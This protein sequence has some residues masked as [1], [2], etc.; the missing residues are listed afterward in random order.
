MT[1]TLL[2]C[3][4]SKI[5]NSTKFYGRFELGTWSPGQAITIA[6]AL[7]RGLL[8]ELPGTSITF[9]KIIGTSHEYDTLPGIRECILDI[10]LNLKKII[11]KSEFKIFSP[12]IGFLNVKGPGIIRSRDLKLPFFIN[13]IDP[14]QY[15]AT[16]TNNSQLNIKFLI[17]SGKKYLI[18]TPSSNHYLNWVNLLEKQKPI[19]LI[20]NNKNKILLDNYRKWKK[21]R[22]LNK[23]NFSLSLILL[24]YSYL[25]GFYP[26]LNNKKNILI[27]Y[28]LKNNKKKIK[29]INLINN[30]KKINSLINFFNYNSN[31]IIENNIFNLKK[32][33]KKYKNNKFNKI[34]YFPIDAIFSPILRVNYT[35]EIK[36]SITKRE[37]IFLEIWT[38]GT[39]DPRS[40]IH[41]TIKILIKL[42][43]PLQQLKVNFFNVCKGKVYLNKL[44]SSYFNK[45]IIQLTNSYYKNKNLNKIINNSLKVI[46][47]NKLKN[48]NFLFIRNKNK[49]NYFYYYIINTN[50]NNNI[51]NI[52][53]K[54]FHYKKNYKLKHLL[55]Y[56]LNNNYFFYKD[57]KLIKLLYT[58]FK[59]F[60]F[61][62]K[63]KQ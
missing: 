29:L 63:Q 58:N 34:G 18:H 41:E 26:I 50:I 54:F 13:C 5:I 37:T 4:D 45:K 25:L 1:H 28:I 52:N 49:L 46:N 55:S 57:N 61:Y 19:N 47:F 12:Q 38:N 17:H 22:Y 23:K 62:L 36:N 6:N 30:N 43:L 2:S 53:K 35:I 16:L 33:K 9:V 24:K 60:N 44:N 59:I 27:N 20:E 31:K 56:T 15:I 11:L 40:A 3:I 51:N 7:R 14:N 32:N 8:S 48:I 21:E 10:L 39:I 42:F